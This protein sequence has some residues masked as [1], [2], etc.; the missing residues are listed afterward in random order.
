LSWKGSVQLADGCPSD[1]CVQQKHFRDRDLGNAKFAIRN[2]LVLAGVALILLA[3]I[4]ACNAGASPIE[5][6][7]H[8]DELNHLGPVSLKSGGKLQ[9]VATTNIVGDVVANVGGDRIELTTLMATGVDP[10]SYVAAPSDTAAVH[11]SHVVFANGLGLEAS[12]DEMLESAGG[13]A[14][15]VHLSDGLDVLALTERDEER[16]DS[17][18]HGDA[19]PHVWFSVPN[20]VH[21]V[22]EIEYVLSTLDPDGAGYYQENAR[23]YIAELEEL[24]A[25]VQ[26]QVAQIPVADRRLVTNHPTFAYYAD[27]Y[28]LEQLGAVFPFNPSS[29]PSAQDIAALEEMI[30]EYGVPAVFAE[31]TANPKLLQQVAEDTGVEMIPLYSGSLG[32]PGSGAETYLLMIRFDTDAI[33]NALK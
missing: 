32:E 12:L 27:R 25:W 29:E 7:Q 33:V 11:D 16:Q 5:H 30:Q 10:H 22:E 23:S 15:N 13:E 3:L 6:G 2:R 24:D 1:L 28:G 18:D 26:E 31:T 9:V 19:D 20:V 17:H 4:C 14:A 21:W 8:R